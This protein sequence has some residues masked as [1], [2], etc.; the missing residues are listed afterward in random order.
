MGSIIF[1]QKLNPS[2]SEGYFHENKVTHVKMSYKLHM[3]GFYELRY[4]DSIRKNLEMKYVL[5]FM[6][7]YYFCKNIDILFLKFNLTRN[8]LKPHDK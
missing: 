5:L 1:C 8:Q 7:S 4:F 6:L 3:Y 2:D